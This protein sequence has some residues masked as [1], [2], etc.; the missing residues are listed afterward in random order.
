MTEIAYT[1]LQC[2]RE[3]RAK[4]N[5]KYTI[6]RKKKKKSRKLNIIAK[7]GVLEVSLYLLRIELLF[8]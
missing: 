5:T 3:S 4:S 7:V 1:D 2:K 6:W 8:T